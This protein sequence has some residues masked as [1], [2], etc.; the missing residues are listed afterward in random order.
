[1]S[2]SGDVTGD[3]ARVV[4]VSG[5]VAGL[6]ATYD[7][8]LA[9]AGELD[10]AGDRMRHW[11]A[12]GAATLLDDDLLASAL[13]AP[14]TFAAAE[15]EVLAATTGPDGVLVE[16]LG[17]ELDARAVRLAVRLLQESD[18]LAEVSLAALDQLVGLTLGLG[19]GH[20]LFVTA[21]LWA[22]RV[23]GTTATATLLWPHLPPTAQDALRRQAARSGARAGDWLTTN[24]RL[25]ERLAGG[26]GGLLDPRLLAAL[27]GAG[28]AR[29]T[30]LPGVRVEASARSPRSVADLV[31][32]LAQLSALS[33][34]DRPEMNGT[35][36]VQSFTGADGQ[37]R[38]V[39]Y[40]PGTDD[41]T[42]WPWTQDGDVRDMGTNLHLV[43]AASTA[44]GAGVLAALAHAGVGAGEPVLLA[45]HS[46]GGMQAAQLLGQDHGY[47]VTH[48]V[49]AGAPT[50][51]LAP[52]PPG[53]H[54]L[55]LEQHGDVVP[56]LDGAPNPD[57]R[58]QVTL[59]FDAG[60]L[61]GGDVLGHHGFAAYAAGA[62]AADASTD[63]SVVEQV[64]SLHEAGFLG[65][66]PPG[67]VA[68][69]IYRITREP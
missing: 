30:P 28:R 48:V 44:Y 66:E 47:D 11:S 14:L 34:P 10:V 42:T 64:R 29:T 17:W 52:F 59:T 62:A 58:E 63:P 68:H 51:Q 9:L 32:H 7:R 57:S 39:V 18:D 23:A 69:T 61:T 36:E 5:G 38:H 45:G 67:G 15:R 16:A 50:A 24:P 22:P 41:M 40:L 13:L 1:M 35:V 12:V 2:G 55:S 33:G 65:P 3:G 31:E 27:Y 43:A 56:L 37:R 46:Q 6:T 21:P 19:V 53:S 26:A 25:V 49:T 60:R 8:V 20:A 54:V 4:S